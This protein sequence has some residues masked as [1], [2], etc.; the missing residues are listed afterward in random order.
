MTTVA[1]LYYCTSP[2]VWTADMHQERLEGSRSVG[3]TLTHHAVFGLSIANMQSG[4]VNSDHDGDM[5]MLFPRYFY[6]GAEE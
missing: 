3:I 5:G 2:P 6:F 4:V 1:I